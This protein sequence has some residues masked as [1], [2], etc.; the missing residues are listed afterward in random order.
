MSTVASVDARL[1]GGRAPYVTKESWK[2]AQSRPGRPACGGRAARARWVDPPASMRSNLPALTFRNSS[3][4][5]KVSVGGVCVISS[6]ALRSFA[7][8]A[9]RRLA[10]NLRGEPIVHGQPSGRSDFARQPAA[11]GQGDVIRR[12]GAAAG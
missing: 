1:H 9:A 2:K 12:R 6:P 5:L 3:V 4:T 10:W 7:N 11:R 8:P